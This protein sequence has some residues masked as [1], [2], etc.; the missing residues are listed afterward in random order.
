MNRRL[1]RSTIRAQVERGVE[2]LSARYAAE[3]FIAYFQAGTN[4][5]GP[6]EKLRRLYDEAIDHPLIIG[7]A[8]GTRPDS[9]PDEVLDLLDGYAR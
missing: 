1:P 3:K 8:V 7:L 5:H 9:V 2:K 4:T 6:V